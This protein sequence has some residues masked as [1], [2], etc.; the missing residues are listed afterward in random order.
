MRNCIMGKL[1]NLVKIEKQYVD[2]TLQKYHSSLKV[3]GMEVKDTKLYCIHLQI[4]GKK[5][6]VL[7]FSM[8]WIWLWHFL[9]FHKF[10]EMLTEWPGQITGEGRGLGENPKRSLQVIIVLPCLWR[11]RLPDKGDC[12][13]C[14]YKQLQL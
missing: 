8:I 11:D 2:W 10:V 13:K 12:P 7:A 6:K 5:V 3:K 1:N 9:I 14:N 4:L